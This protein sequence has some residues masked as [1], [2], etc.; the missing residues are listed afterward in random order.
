MFNSLVLPRKP[1]YLDDDTDDSDAH[2]EQPVNNRLKWGSSEFAQR[3]KTPNL[4]DNENESRQKIYNKP[5][6]T[7]RKLEK[8]QQIAYVSSDEV[9]TGKQQSTS[10]LVV[11]NNSKLYSKPRQNR[12]EENNRRHPSRDSDEDDS[13]ISRDSRK[14]FSSSE[15]V[16]YVSAKGDNRSSNK[17]NFVDSVN[18]TR[19]LRDSASD[20]RVYRYEEGSKTMNNGFKAPFRESTKGPMSST[21]KTIEKVRPHRDMTYNPSKADFEKARQLLARTGKINKL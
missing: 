4:V 14:A 7:N 8:D 20:D 3:N 5:H 15:Y 6:S 18:N 13:E 19:K 9:I 1:S 16:P 2:A 10:E 17:D 21:P 12:D 11:S